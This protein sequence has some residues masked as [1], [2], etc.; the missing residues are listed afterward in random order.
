M[1]QIIKFWPKTGLNQ[2]ILAKNDLQTTLII[3]VA[4]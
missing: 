3:I 2:N 1:P 4:P